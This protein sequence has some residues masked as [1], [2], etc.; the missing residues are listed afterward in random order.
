MMPKTNGMASKGWRAKVELMTR[1]SL[2]KMPKGG[3][4]AIANTP[5]TSDQPS[6]G[7]VTVSPRMSAIFW[8]PLTWAMWPTL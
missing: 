7:W 2:V 8:L 1:N 4:P 3:K 6:T 5:T